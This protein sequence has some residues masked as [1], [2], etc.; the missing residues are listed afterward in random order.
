MSLPVV[1]GGVPFALFVFSGDH[2]T[3]R[4]VAKVRVV[5][6]PMPGVDYLVGVPTSGAIR[7]LHFHRLG[8]LLFRVK[9]VEGDAFR[10][11]FSVLKG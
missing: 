8:R 2:G 5:G 6:V 11:V 3:F 1:E 7:F 4:P 10:L 9:S